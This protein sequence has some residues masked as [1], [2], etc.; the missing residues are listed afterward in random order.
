MTVV[1]SGMLNIGKLP[2]R[3]IDSRLKV[4]LSISSE[5]L[6]HD[7]VLESNQRQEVDG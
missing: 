3:N 5:K 7:N 2:V 4:R 6:R 1:R